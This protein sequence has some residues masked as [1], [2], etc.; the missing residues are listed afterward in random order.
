MASDKKNEIHWDISDWMPYR[1]WSVGR[2]AAQRMRDLSLKRYGLKPAGWRA[3]ANIGSRA[4]LSSKELSRVI[5]L[6]PVQTSRAVDQL[7]RQQLITRRIDQ[8]DRRRVEL[9]LSRKGLKIYNA[10][11]PVAEDI[12]ADLLSPLSAAERREFRRLI[13]KVQDRLQVADH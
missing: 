11:A 9:R 6:D 13:S 2:H 7:V 10:I 3:L 8:E 12:E 4:P 5:G 1:M